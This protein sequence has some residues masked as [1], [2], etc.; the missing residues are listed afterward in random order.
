MDPEYI[1]RMMKTGKT[2]LP[3]N[4]LEEPLPEWAAELADD[5]R[6]QRMQQLYTRDGRRTGNATIAEIVYLHKYLEAQFIVATDAGNI[7]KM[8]YNEVCELFEFGKYIMKEFPNE[9]IYS[10]LKEY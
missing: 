6:L 5:T 9:I 8:T 4:F 1:E 10:R 7:M 3:D 2:H